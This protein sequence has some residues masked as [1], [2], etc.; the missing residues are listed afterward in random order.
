MET[1][2]LILGHSARAGEEDKSRTGTCFIMTRPTKPGPTSGP[3]DATFVLVTAKHVL[4]D[5]RGEQATVMLRKRNGTGDAVR[6]PFPLKIRDHGKNLY[7]EHP[8]ADVAVI[9]V[10][11]PNDS[12]IFEVAKANNIAQISW[13]ATDDFLRDIQIHPGDQLFCLGY[14]FGKSANDAG[15]SVLRS[16]EIASYPII[17]LKKAGEILYDFRVNPGDSG[18]PVYL[19]M[20]DRIYKG[21]FNPMTRI[22]YQKIFGLVTKKADAVDNVDP[23]IGLIVS[24]IYIK[25]AIDRMAGFEATITDN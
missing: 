7:T 20:T 3:Y 14:P 8:S 15:Y 5:I 22:V 21:Q 17:P 6:V 12:I 11:F 2:F 19:A 16:G 18:G 23:S 4:A 25:E 13:L 10:A 24:S 9:D 1:T